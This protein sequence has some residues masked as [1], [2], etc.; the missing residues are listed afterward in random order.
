[1]SHGQQ[2]GQHEPQWGTR[3]PGTPGGTS[4]ERWREY[5]VDD[6]D[7]DDRSM[8]RADVRHQQS[9]WSVV[10]VL[11]SELVDG[12]ERR[13]AGDR[14]ECRLPIR[15]YVHLGEL[16]P[17]DVHIDLHGGRLSAA[18]VRDRP[19]GVRLYSVESYGNGIFVFE[20][21]ATPVDD[22]LADGWTVRVRP[23]PNGCVGLPVAPVVGWCA[24]P[25]PRTGDG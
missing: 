16:T 2:D 25:A 8:R 1:M 10:R 13:D 15:A 17:A 5:V 7:L 22:E 12:A 3:E 21:C 23:S 20:G 24:P 14:R 11:D 19:D 4:R 6:V 18:D 9:W